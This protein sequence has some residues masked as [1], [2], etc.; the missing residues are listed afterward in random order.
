MLCVLGA[1]LPG[2]LFKQG[3]NFAHVNSPMLIFLRKFT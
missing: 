2:M 3:L 1:R